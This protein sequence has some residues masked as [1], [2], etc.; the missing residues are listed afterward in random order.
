MGLVKAC[1]RLLNSSLEGVFGGPEA[2]RQAFDMMARLERSYPASSLVVGLSFV[3][4]LVYYEPWPVIPL[5]GTA[6]GYSL[7]L[8]WPAK[9]NYPYLAA[10][11]G[12][13]LGLSCSM[14]AARLAGPPYAFLWVGAAMSLPFVAV[15][16][17]T[18]VTVVAVVV[19]V[20]AMA[21]VALLWVPERAS[22]QPPA[23]L[24]P[25]FGLVATVFMIGLVREVDRQHR[26]AVLTDVLTGLGN[27]AAIDVYKREL[28]DAPTS[29]G[30]P[31][32]MVVFDLDHFKA[33]N[34]ELGH[35]VG[36]EALRATAAALSESL[37]PKAG[38]FRYGGEEFVVL[39]P[40]MDQAAAVAAAERLRQAV[41]RVSVHGRALTVSGGVVLDRVST[42]LDLTAMFQRADA[43]LYDAKNQGRN[44]V[45]VGL[46]QVTGLNR[47]HTTVRARPEAG[48][49]GA[50][51]SLKFVRTRLERDHLRVMWDALRGPRIARKLNLAMLA[52][53][54]AGTY[55][56]GWGPALLALLAA[57]V[58]D[59]AVR[60]NKALS[61]GVRGREMGLF[62]E[63]VFCMVI[64]SLAI[65]TAKVEALYL[66]PLMIVPAFPSIVGYRALGAVI[67]AVIAS[68]L[69]VVTGCVT[70]W[71]TVVE[72]PLIVSLP[73]GFIGTVAAVGM[74]L[75]RST[76]EN[77]AAASIDPLTGALNRGALEAR[78]AELARIDASAY[79]PVTLI[80]ADLDH[81]K[82]IN[83]T[84]GHDAG[85]E[86]LVDVARRMQK[87]LRLVDV[88]YRVGGE[89]FVVLLPRTGRPEA[90][91]IA[92]R[93]REAISEHPCG[94]RPLTVS[95]GISSSELDDEF[96]YAP[97]F[98]RADA[99]LLEAKE[100]GRNRVV[101]AAREL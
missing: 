69:V 95:L 37:P 78:V 49:Q 63:S 75:V 10:T 86:V 22:E 46:P 55:W 66:L 59:P 71:S 51:R 42:E 101:V 79:E 25:L 32:A 30:R 12:W 11:V 14:I 50:R 96:D 77:A 41:E 89:E 68:V 62:W 39:L 81:F 19:L 97:A 74:A 58:L 88:L 93:L 91:R 83:D 5:I 9:S 1:L 73:I 3:P 85:D 56:L 84:Y 48:E 4:G 8:S 64:L 52:A 2:H 61:V 60:T 29:I 18:R 100:H 70:A 20:I 53:A 67:T 98:D 40:L 92:E 45:L 90:E 7:A 34:D 76:M 27:R 13:L 21:S 17:P 28:L 15:I 6:I 31:I 26:E 43:A 33:L 57:I 36:D 87:E 23:L 44:R 35:A 82:Q 99:A 80:V 24:G 38:V 54:V 72:N 47:Q 65:A 16:W 94:G